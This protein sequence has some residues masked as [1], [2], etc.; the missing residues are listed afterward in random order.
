M[1]AE[2]LLRIPPSDNNLQLA[3]LERLDQNGARIRIQRL[4]HS[5]VWN[6]VARYE[7]GIRGDARP[8]QREPL[9]QVEA[10]FFA[11]PEVDER[12]IDLRG[13]ENLLGFV[14]CCRRE[15]DMA[16][17]TEP[18]TERSSDG[19]LIVHVKD[20]RQGPSFSNRC[21][22]ANCIAVAALTSQIWD[23][24]QGEEEPTAV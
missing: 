19:A 5:S 14:D 2:C 9:E 23:E 15:D 18:G 21:V 13:T 4:L 8:V 20:T 6:D 24:P 7:D 1:C 10:A 22:A 16:S 12:S 11:K 3:Q 17:A